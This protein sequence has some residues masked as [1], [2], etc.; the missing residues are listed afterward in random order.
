MNIIKKY[1]SKNLFYVSVI[2]TGITSLLFGMFYALFKANVFESASNNFLEGTGVLSSYITTTTGKPTG[3]NYFMV[4]LIISLLFFFIIS[5][6]L[7]L[8]LKKSYFKV[9]NLLACL[10][11]VLVI[12]LVLAC[13]FINISSIFSYAILIIS[14]I[15]YLFI[16][17]KT[18]DKLFNFKL[19]QRIISLLIFI[20]PIIVILILLKL[21]V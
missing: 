21:F 2:I 4:G 6:L 14:A 3:V 19:K 18:L 20:G 15:L 11:I 13:L 9:F 17:Y 1:L 7:N 5:L 10:N 16:F 8:Y 12:G